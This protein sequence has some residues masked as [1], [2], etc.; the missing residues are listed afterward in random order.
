MDLLLALSKSACSLA[1]SS[2]PSWLFSVLGGLSLNDPT[3]TLH[4]SGVMNTLPQGP[5]FQTLVS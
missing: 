1:K 5:A 2:A 4:T 3:Y